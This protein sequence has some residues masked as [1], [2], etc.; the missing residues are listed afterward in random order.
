MPLKPA[1]L[2]KK[3]TVTYVG[4]TKSKTQLATSLG[5]GTGDARNLKVGKLTLSNVAVATTMG[6]VNCYRYW[7]S[8]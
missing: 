6:Q 2:G 7:S 5:T 3:V 8:Q 4:A 1:P